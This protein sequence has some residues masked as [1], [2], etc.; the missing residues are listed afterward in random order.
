MREIIFY[1]PAGCWDEMKISNQ[2]SPMVYSIYTYIERDRDDKTVDRF[3]NEQVYQFCPYGN[4]QNTNCDKHI[5]H[6]RFI[7][8]S[9]STNEI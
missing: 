3:L 5:D 2:H 8:V 7:D 9:R 1:R 4:R 6:F